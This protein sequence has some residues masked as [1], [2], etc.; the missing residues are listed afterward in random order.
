MVGDGV[1]DDGSALSDVG[2]SDAEAGAMYEAFG[3]CDVDAH[4][5]FVHS[6]GERAVS[7]PARVAWFG[8]AI[9]D[10]PLRNMMIVSIAKGPSSVADGPSVA[11]GWTAAVTACGVPT[12]TGG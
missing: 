3:A 6:I 5:A 2:L 7:R 4:T 8:N 9:D 1:D 10:E 12:T 11:E